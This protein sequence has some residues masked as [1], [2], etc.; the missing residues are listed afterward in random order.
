MPGKA[1]NPNYD[2]VRNQTVQAVEETLRKI[3]SSGRSYNTLAELLRSV[4]VF[5]GVSRSTLRPY[6]NA[7]AYHRVVKFFGSQAIDPTQV[8][9][10]VADEF[11]L[12]TKLALLRAE[13][14]E[15]KRNLR[16]RERESK[17]LA[18]I[19]AG[20]SMIM[21]LYHVLVQ[22]ML[23]SHGSVRVNER[24]A[25]IE[26]RFPER[27]RDPIVASG[28]AI[29]RFARWLRSHPTWGSRQDLFSND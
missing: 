12:R 2:R 8:P 23:R 17:A 1:A 3:Q 25:W 4:S 11:I 9:D 16:G 6:R 18:P 15:L 22:I 21:E 10:D 14:A 20:E 13:N 24:R 26:D 19:G 5:S 7:E 28:E 29:G 27:G